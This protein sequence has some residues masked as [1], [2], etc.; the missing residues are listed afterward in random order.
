MV[1]IFEKKTH[2]NQTQTVK[3]FMFYV[4][5][6]NSTWN[7]IDNQPHTSCVQQ[8]PRHASERDIIEW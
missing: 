6:L 1:I 4:K 3:P 8:A 7:L 2:I 5:L